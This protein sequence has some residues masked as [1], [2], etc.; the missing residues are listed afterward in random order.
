MNYQGRGRYSA[1]AD[2]C[3]GGSWQLTQAQGIS[4]FRSLHDGRGWMTDKLQRAHKMPI[5][6]S[7]FGAYQITLLCFCTFVLYLP[8]CNATNR[9]IQRLFLLQHL[10]L[11]LNLN[12]LFDPNQ[13]RPPVIFQSSLFTACG[14]G[15]ITFTST[16]PDWSVQLPE[17]SHERSATRTILQKRVAFWKYL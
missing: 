4:W 15:W 10:L 6:S 11:P 5:L 2:E 16:E 7:I 9:L 12:D 13:P 14:C 1:D 3:W 17:N 8:L